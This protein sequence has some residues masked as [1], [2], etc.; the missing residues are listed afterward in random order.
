MEQYPTHFQTYPFPFAPI[1]PFEKL[2]YIPYPHPYQ[3]KP[4]LSIC[5][6][7]SIS[8]LPTHI[9]ILPISLTLVRITEPQLYPDLSRQRDPST[10][11]IN[12]PPYPPFSPNIH[13]VWNQELPLKA[14]LDVKL[15][16]SKSF[17]TNVCYV[18]L[19]IVTVSS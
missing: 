9:P 17:T 4:S 14:N 19:Y 6:T 3:P 13:L 5:T 12:H 15:I 16:I 1:H 7:L 2:C 18:A 11:L 10:L 8:S